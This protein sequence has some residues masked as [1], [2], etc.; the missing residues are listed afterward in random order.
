MHQEIERKF[1]VKGEYKSQATSMIH[2]EQGYLCSVSARTVRVRIYGEMGFITVKG[3]SPDGGISR[4]EWEKEISASEAKALL[5]LCEPGRINKNRYLITIG[6]HVYE[7]DEF[8]EENTG[9]VL[10]EIEL[11]R[12][13][14]SFEKPEWLGTEVT[15]DLRYYNALLVKHPYTSW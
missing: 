13:D 11:R 10:A 3:E 15:G 8:L 1:L 6:N 9:L 5:A 2:I 4:F 12:A 14:E 7:V